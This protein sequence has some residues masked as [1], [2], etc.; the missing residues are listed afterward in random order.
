ME[1]AT[2]REHLAEKLS[3]LRQRM[4]LER[5]A[6][7]AALNYSYE[8]LSYRLTDKAMSPFHVEIP[9]GQ[10]REVVPL[11]HDGEEFHYLLAGEAQFEIGEETHRLVAGDSIYFDS[12]Q[13]HSRARRR[14]SAG[15]DA[16]LPGQ[17]TAP[18]GGRQPHRTGSLGIAMTAGINSGAAEVAEDRLRCIAVIG[19]AGKMGRGIALLLAEEMTRLSR[20][21]VLGGRIS[22]TLDTRRYPGSGPRRAGRLHKGTRGAARAARYRANPRALFVHLGKVRS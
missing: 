6:A 4:G 8:A 10:S 2:F 13:A 12:R 14:L 16:S 5:A 3:R 22:A 18:G 9:P 20:G 21:G 11:S 1:E 15:A 19:A 17:R 7:A